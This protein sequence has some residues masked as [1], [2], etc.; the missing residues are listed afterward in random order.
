MRTRIVVT[1]LAATMNMMA[2]KYVATKRIF[3][4]KFTFS[5]Y[6]NTHSNIYP[7]FAYL[8]TIKI[9]QAINKFCD[10]LFMMS[11]LYGGKMTY[12]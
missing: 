5:A 3:K 11:E 2:L 7:L 8:I 12:L 10:I 6:I 4:L 9:N 1:T